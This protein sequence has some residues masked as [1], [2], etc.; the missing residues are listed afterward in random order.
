VCF[1]TSCSSS[2]L[3]FCF[4]GAFRADLRGFFA[5]V[6][7]PTDTCSGCQLHNQSIRVSTSHLAPSIA[8]AH[9]CPCREPSRQA[10]SIYAHRAMYSGLSSV[11]LARSLG[12]SIAI[13]RKWRRRMYTIR[14]RGWCDVKCKR[15]VRGRIRFG[16]SLDARST[17]NCESWGDETPIG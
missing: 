12:L 10:R 6:S 15:V 9:S 3:S 7:S 11:L 2:P 17:S 8:S 13:S 1:S 5:S 16:V 14:R 4:S